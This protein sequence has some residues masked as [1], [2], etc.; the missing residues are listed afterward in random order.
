MSTATLNYPGFYEQKPIL[1][2]GNSFRRIAEVWNRLEDTVADKALQECITRLGLNDEP[3]FLVSLLEDFLTA[4]PTQVAGIRS[5]FKS[6]NMKDLSY[7]SHT[8]KG[9][10]SVFGAARLAT[11]CRI[12]EEAASENNP[13]LAED[14][15]ERLVE[16]LEHDRKLLGRFCNRL[17]I[18]RV[19]A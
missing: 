10:S 5:T 19:A 17:R 7:Y 4:A 9:S 3:E 18:E 12:I 13:D 15:V 14:T 1:I 2:G 6:R 16:D 11:S 8:L